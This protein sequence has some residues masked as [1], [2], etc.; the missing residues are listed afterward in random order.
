MI[1]SSPA[2]YSFGNRPKTTSQNF[3]DTRNPLG[4]GQYSLP[5]QKVYKKTVKTFS[6]GKDEKLKPIKSTTPGPGEYE[7]DFSTFGKNVPK[8][9]ISKSNRV[10]AFD[11]SGKNKKYNQPGPGQYNT[12]SSITSSKK[13][14]YLPKTS[15]EMK[16]TNKNPG[17][18]EY[19][20]P[21]LFGKT[22]YKNGIP[23]H[24][25]RETYLEKQI[26]LDTNPG[27]GSYHTKSDFDQS[28]KNGT[29]IRGKPKEKIDNGVPGPGEYSISEKELKTKDT[30]P[31]FSIGGE[32]RQFFGISENNG[33]NIGPGMYDAKEPTKTS[34][35]FAF[36]KEK[37]FS[38]P[39]STTPGPGY[40][41]IPCG[42]VN[43]PTYTEDK[44]D[45]DFKYV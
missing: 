35:A 44:F 2:V 31:K 16:I 22:G 34:K 1:Y 24:D 3:I 21:E 20:Q 26:R 27:Q 5:N 30:A 29:I 32:K 7:S 36:S 45:P 10:S 11:K 8:Y 37:K 28:N 25:K 38:G 42:I 23:Q 4:P 13:G 15:K 17:P 9:S 19:E 41:K 33:N 14:V 6:F 40:Y 12:E 18:G 39:V 43:V